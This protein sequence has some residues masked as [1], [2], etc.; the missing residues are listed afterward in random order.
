MTKNMILKV[1]NK[2]DNVKISPFI[3]WPAAILLFVTSIFL[4]NFADINIVL[5]LNFVLFWTAV[6]VTVLTLNSKK[7]GNKFARV[8]AVIFFIIGGQIN[9]LLSPNYY[10]QDEYF[11]SYSNVSSFDVLVVITFLIYFL[12]KY[13][14][15]ALN[16]AAKESQSP[17]S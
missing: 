1:I 9:R 13:V 10:Y 14:Y 7:A 4:I 8:M 6:L 3:G 2:I 16:K 11:Y 12:S 15:K 5:C 17:Q